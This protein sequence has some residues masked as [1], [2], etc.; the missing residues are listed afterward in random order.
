MGW[1]LKHDGTK[2]DRSKANVT[3]PQPGVYKLKIIEA[4][5]E[6][7]N[8]SHPDRIVFKAQQVEADD[9]GK[10]VGYTYWDYVNL[11]IDWKIDNWLNAVGVET[12]GKKAVG[13]GEETFVGK[14]ISGRIIKDTFDGEYRPKLKSVMPLEDDEDEDEI[15]PD[16]DEDETE[17]EDAGD[18]D[19]DEDEE[20]GDDDDEDDED[21]EDEDDDDEDPDFEDDD[22][23]DD[24][25][26][27]ED[28]EEE[29]PPPPPAKKKKAPA[30]EPEPPAKKTSAKKKKYEDM[31]DE[32]LQKELKKRELPVKGSRTA[33]IARLRKND[34]EP[35]A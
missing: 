30:P 16:E 33:V 18:S 28:E 24:D 8:G 17:D 31:T 22:D 25:E 23:E 26:D 11:D 14:E 35:F 3:P 19:D 2:V 4:K 20:E 32:E 29:T 13:Y 27:D 21:D 12:E 10:G 34:A 15:D 5:Y 6:K 1:K 7:D 9:K